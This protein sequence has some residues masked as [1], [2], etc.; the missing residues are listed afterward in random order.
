MRRIFFI[1]WLICLC[2]ML[3][4]MDNDDIYIDLGFGFG[5]V[6]HR[7]GSSGRDISHYPSGAYF[8][9]VEVSGNS[10]S[11]FSLKLG[12][13]IMEDYPLYG[14]LSFDRLTRSVDIYDHY[15][16]TSAVDEYV[17]YFVGPGVVYYPADAIQFSSS[18]GMSFGYNNLGRGFRNKGGHH[19]YHHHHYHHQ[20]NTVNID[21]G[22]AFNLSVAYDHSIK[23]YPGLLIGIKYFHSNNDVIYERGRRDKLSTSTISIFL[24]YRFFVIKERYYSNSR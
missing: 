17:Q 15:T 12:Y 1:I 20:R 6:R 13:A 24:K 9:T 3:V 21:N 14:V 23:D 4:A 11:E 22:F 8:Q 18:L 19:H 2:G 5:G 16:F 10:A 7:L